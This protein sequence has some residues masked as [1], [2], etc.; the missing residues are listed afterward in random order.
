M[1]GALVAIV[2]AVAAVGAARIWQHRRARAISRTGVRVAVTATCS[3]CPVD[4]S[5]HPPRPRVVEQTRDGRC[6]TCGSEAITTRGN[7][8]RAPVHVETNRDVAARV[9]RAWYERKRGAA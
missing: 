4:T 9:V 7:V 6:G 8:Y 5:V 1:I 2:V 3:D